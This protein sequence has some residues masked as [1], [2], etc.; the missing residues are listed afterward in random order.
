MTVFYTSDTH[1][2]HGRILALAGRPFRDIR[3]HD[4][5]LIQ[6]WN[7]VVGDGDDIYHL[8]DFC[9]A[10]E[11]E[12]RVRGIFFRLAGRKRL[13]IGNHDVD[14]DGRLLPMLAD[15]PWEEAPAEERAIL[16]NGHSV[17]LSHYPPAAGRKIADGS[18]FFYGHLHARLPMDRRSRDVGVDMPDVDFTPRT[19]EELVVAMPG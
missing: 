3:D 4:E 15:L 12:A 16:D 14:G 10:T 8:G 11:D 18:Y 7:S 5:T 1:F 2:C 13:I 17:I 6:R 19:I 9:H